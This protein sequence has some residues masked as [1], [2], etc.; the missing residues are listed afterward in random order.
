MNRTLLALLLLPLPLAACETS[1]EVYVAPKDV[2]TRMFLI[3]PAMA[4]ELLKEDGGMKIAAA[5]A[6]H[7]KAIQTFCSGR[8]EFVISEGLVLSGAVWLAKQGISLLLDEANEALQEELKKYTAAY[9][10]ASRGNFYQPVN[11]GGPKLRYTCFR[12]SAQY[13]D[14]D[15][16]PL[17]AMD[18]VGR[19]QSADGDALTVTPLRLYYA[20]GQ[21]LTDA[22]GEIGVSLSLKADAYWRENNK[23]E[24]RLG[25]FDSTVLKEKVVLKGDVPFYKTY[26]KLDR[27]AIDPNSLWPHQV[28]GPLP[29]FTADREIRFGGSQTVVTV[30]VVEAG[31]TPLLLK[32]AAKLLQDNK[33]KIETK[34]GEAVDQLAAGLK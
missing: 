24:G 18:F 11:A 9:S 13:V 34:L 22:S 25:A 27:E 32:Q 15:N 7:E 26:F 21:A 5:D 29:P 28:I 10:G 17:A 14:K 12:M 31:K 8:S 16:K 2:T 30:T 4:A 1:R 6:V 3:E 33:D 20:K 19:L 23:G